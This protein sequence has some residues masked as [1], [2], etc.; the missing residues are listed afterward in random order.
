[1]RGKK[2]TKFTQFPKKET[3]FGGLELCALD[4]KIEE[5]HKYQENLEDETFTD[6]LKTSQPIKAGW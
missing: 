5:G 3:S 6:A 2:L 1:M 4:E